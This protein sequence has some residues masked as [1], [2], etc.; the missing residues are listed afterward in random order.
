MADQ[1]HI[2][3][4]G[5]KEAIA[6]LDDVKRRQIPFA[7]SKA[8]NECARMIR[9]EERLTMQQVFDRPTPWTLNALQIRPAS[10][11]KLTA[12]VE[13]KDQAERYLGPQIY[14]GE[15]RMKR[16]EMWLK[17]YWAPG[18]AARR[19]RYGNMSAG[20]ITQIL[21]ATKTHPDFY[22]WTSRRSLKRN[23]KPRDYFIVRTPRGK[24][25]PGVWEKYGKAGAIRP[26]LKFIAS[27]K[28]R[29][30]FPFYEVAHRVADAHLT[31]LFKEA[32]DYAIQTAR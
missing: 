4:R 9:D 11:T 18:G 28:Y 14:G 3:L 31:R 13:F 21:S 15:R 12:I 5:V 6:M 20:Q 24:V 30:L 27:P 17:A 10:K 19:N 32:L 26:I 2:E 7:V 23:K 25:F 22:A 8:L 29:K 16:S 1:I